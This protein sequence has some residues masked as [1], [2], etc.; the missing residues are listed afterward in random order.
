MESF[1]YT[2]SPYA[3]RDDIKQAYRQGTGHGCRQQA[4]GGLAPPG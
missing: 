1:T 2:D 4:A 3:I